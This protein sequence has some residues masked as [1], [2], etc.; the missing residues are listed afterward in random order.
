MDVAALL[1]RSLSDVDFA[2]ETLERFRTRVDDDLVT[3]R[4]HVVNRAPAEV[5]EG[6]W[7]LAGSVLD[8]TDLAAVARR[9][10]LE[11]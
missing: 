1:D 4:Q 5:F 7:S 6:V 3:I 11:R 10:G 8:P 2:K 9:L